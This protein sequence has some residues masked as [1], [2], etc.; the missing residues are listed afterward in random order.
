MHNSPFCF[1]MSITYHLSS[2]WR[3]EILSGIILV[4][5]ALWQLYIWR[6]ST[7]SWDVYFL[8]CK[9]LSSTLEN[10]KVRLDI[11]S[12]K[13]GPS[14]TVLKKQEPSWAEIVGYET[15]NISH[16]RSTPTASSKKNSFFSQIADVCC[17]DVCPFVLFLNHVDKYRRQSHA[18]KMLKAG[19]TIRRLQVNM[20]IWWRN[21]IKFQFKLFTKKW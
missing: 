16:P 19:K 8:K 3:A 11:E 4:V 17:K 7:I 2:P 12:T 18:Q 9:R 5:S 21:L 20:T 6:S 13:A 15:K 14:A 10:M 1:W